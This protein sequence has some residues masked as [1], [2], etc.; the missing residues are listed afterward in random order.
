MCQAIP[1]EVLRI[2]AGKAQVLI[3]GRP[4]WVLTQ[5]LPD[6]RRG[7]FVL[8]YAGQALQRMDR[9]E[10]ETLLQ[11][12]TD[13]DAMFDSLFEE[14]PDAPAEASLVPSVKGEAS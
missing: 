4:T 9:E 6:L 2:E 11:E 10:A 5:A 12:I 13:L 8:V 3:D 1:R 14:P 7:E